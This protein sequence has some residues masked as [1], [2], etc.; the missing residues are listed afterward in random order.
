MTESWQDIPGYE[1]LYL[2]SN[3]GRILSKHLQKRSDGIKQQ[4]AHQGYL[5]VSLC[6][7]SIQ[8]NHA[9]H[10]LVIEV[11]IGPCPD[12]M[13][14]RHLDGNRKNNRAENLCWG[15]AKENAKDRVIHG[16]NNIGKRNGMAKLTDNDVIS[17]RKIKQPQHVI[18]KMFGV[19]QSLIS[20]IKRNKIWRHVDEI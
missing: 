10:R 7:K 8:K 2:V 15:T 12:G 20:L 5:Y 18:A 9:V 19:D 14:C 17:I 16:T 13:Q 4:Y 3:H 6:K 11:F 1:G